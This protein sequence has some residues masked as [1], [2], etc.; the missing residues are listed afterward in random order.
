MC[1]SPAYNYV[2]WE[3]SSSLRFINFPNA[4][5]GKASTLT[6][7]AQ[8]PH[9]SFMAKRAHPLLLCLAA[10]LAFSC[11]LIPPSLLLNTP[12]KPTSPRRF[13]H[14]LLA[15]LHPAPSNMTPPIDLVNPWR[16]HTFPAEKCTSS[17]LYTAAEQCALKSQRWLNWVRLIARLC[18]SLRSH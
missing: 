8:M 4:L 10:L 17:D 3:L 5:R 18:H 13:H 2:S 7:C 15:D 11:S 9:L 12:Y 14:N 6:P 16:N 1:L